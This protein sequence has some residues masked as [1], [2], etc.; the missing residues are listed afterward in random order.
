MAIRG[1]L[2]DL[3]GVVYT[4]TGPVPG[5]IRA[6]ARLRAAGIAIR[7]LTNTTRRSA[8][9]LSA[10]LGGIGLDVAAGELLTP[11][12]AAHG[13]LAGRGLTPHLLVHPAFEEDFSG[14]PADG[15]PA[16]VV[17]DAGD[18]FSYARLNAAYRL[19]EDGA[20][21]L[22][23]AMN[24]NFR[25]ED[26]GLS[27]DAGPFIAALEYAARRAPTV[28]GKPAPAFFRAGLA[29]LGCAPGEALMIG[30]DAESDIGG[31]ADIGI[32]GVLV[33]T[34]KYRPGDETHLPRPPAFIADDL[35]TAVD[36][37]LAG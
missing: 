16:V 9:R 22:A 35:A 4:G 37:I 7:C 24:R 1:V 36:R 32:P 19:I 21:F 3:G 8:A 14:L 5:S 12:L 17:G 30:D 27:L 34:G 11:A 29:G 20:A 15:P 13:Y 18:A 28:L 25:D 33:R 26:D 10:D 23:L 31:A 6:V 2:L